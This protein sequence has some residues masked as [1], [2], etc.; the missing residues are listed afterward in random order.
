MSRGTVD[1]A[2]PVRLGRP[3]DR[4]DRLIA[5][6]GERAE[7]WATE[8]SIDDGKTWHPATIYRGATI[9]EWRT[10]NYAAWNKGTTQG[11]IPRGR[12][13]CLWNYFFDVEMP[14]DRAML[15][16]SPL[17]QISRQH[18]VARTSTPS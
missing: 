16:V 18:V 11:V 8:Y 17:G 3:L 9:D 1:G 14:A 10:C 7:E 6:L 2:E 13:R 5:I 15:R 4:P 12:Q